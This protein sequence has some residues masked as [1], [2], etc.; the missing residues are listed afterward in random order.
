MRPV[1]LYCFL[2]IRLPC[3]AQ[4]PSD[5]LTELDQVVER[6]EVVV[7]VAFIQAKP[8]APLLFVFPILK[9]CKQEFL[10]GFDRGRNLK[11]GAV[12]YI[13][14]TSQTPVINVKSEADATM[15]IGVVAP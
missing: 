3:F 13:I 5:N 11:V 7:A 2:D 9:F 10:D 12:G 8:I 4:R 15:L 14:D 6:V 1:S